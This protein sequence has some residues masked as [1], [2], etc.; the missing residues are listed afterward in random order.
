METPPRERGKQ[1]QTTKMNMETS[2][3]PQ[4]LE[5]ETRK[6]EDQRIPWVMCQAHHSRK[7]G[8]LHIMGANKVFGRRLYFVDGDFRFAISNQES[9][10]F[11]RLLMETG[12]IT[13]EQFTKTML[14]MTKEKRFGQLLV[15]QNFISQSELEACVDNQVCDIVYST[16][17]LDSGLYFFEERKLKLPADLNRSFDFGT[18]VLNGTRAMRNLILLHNEMEKYLDERLAM[19]EDPVVPVEKLPITPE[20]A[21]ALSRVDGVMTTEQLSRIS[22]LDQ[23]TFYRFIYA[24]LCLNILAPVRQQQML[25]N[26]LETMQQAGEQPPLPATSGA[27]YTREQASD[28]EAI[29]KKYVS[30]KKDTYWTYLGV[31]MRADNKTLKEAYLKLNKRFH[32]DVALRSHL[33]DLAPYLN[34]II[35][36]LNH[37][38]HVMSDPKL[39][40]QYVDEMNQATAKP[41]DGMSPQERQKAGAEAFALGMRYLNQEDLFNAHRYFEQAVR[42][43]P[44]D[45]KYALEFGKLQMRNPNWQGKAKATFSRILEKHPNH[46]KTHYAMAKLLIS[47]GFDQLAG[48]HLRQAVDLDPANDEAQ[49]LL[50]SLIQEKKSNSLLDRLRGR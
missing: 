30:I 8:I 22:P 15:E 18:L 7:S 21:F 39:R 11:G 13:K 49:V 35:S 27:Q 33:A 12:V 1:S 48:N 26:R 36:H 46:A 25:A 37:T 4:S 24:L 6:I 5:F 34:A 9:D 2:Q 45:P 31:P 29:V 14:K 42:L 43:C 3:K 19:A 32:P 28:R 23:D 41:S 20:E 50:D 38:Y 17:E 47:Q 44:H 40:Q 10:R 16:F